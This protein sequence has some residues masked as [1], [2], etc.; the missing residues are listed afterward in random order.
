MNNFLYKFRAQK[1]RP[2][3]RRLLYCAIYLSQISAANTSRDNKTCQGSGEGKKVRP[4]WPC[5]YSFF[6]THLDSNNK[7][8]VR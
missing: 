7:T 5:L 4:S 2:P 1:I 6:Q 8:T 3:P